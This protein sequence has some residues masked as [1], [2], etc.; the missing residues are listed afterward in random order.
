MREFR[1]EIQPDCITATGT[2]LKAQKQ[3]ATHM[4]HATL[5]N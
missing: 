3:K 5:S 1:T 4:T 2:N